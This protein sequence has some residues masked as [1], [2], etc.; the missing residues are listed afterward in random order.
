M[1]RHAECRLSEGDAVEIVTFVGGGPG[2]PSVPADKPLVVGGFTFQIEF[3]PA[4]TQ[5]QPSGHVRSIL[6]TLSG[7][8]Q[9]RAS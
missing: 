9:R 3:L 5:P 2:E 1:V 7:P 4:E 6:E 8:P